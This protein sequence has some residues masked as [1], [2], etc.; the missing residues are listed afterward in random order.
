MSLL[1]S[2]Q[3]L[4]GSSL[5]SAIRVVSSAY[6]RLLIFLLANLIPAC[7]SPSCPFPI[8]SLALSAY[9]SPQTIHFRVLDKSAVSGPGRG[10]P[11]CNKVIGPCAMIFGFLMTSFKP[12][13]SL[14]SF[15]L[16]KELF[17]SSSLFSIK[18]I[19]SA[20][21]RLLIFLQAI[22]ILASESSSPASHMMFSV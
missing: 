1:H 15:T 6:L 19:S 5:L 2:H 8:K 12:T 13:F 10:P 22:L 7:A 20:Y 11:S 4:F 3:E 9:A 16:I 18:V 21:L 17:S 14:S